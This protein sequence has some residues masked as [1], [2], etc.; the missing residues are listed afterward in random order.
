MN[1]YKHLTIDEREKAMVF[2]EKG[3]S[4]RRIAKELN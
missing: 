3:L 1:H 4:F 2:R